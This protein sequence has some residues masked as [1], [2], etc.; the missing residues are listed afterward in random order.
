MSTRTYT[1]TYLARVTQTRTVSDVDLEDMDRQIL[2]A[3]EAGDDFNGGPVLTSDVDEILE[4][5]DADHED[6]VAIDDWQLTI[7]RT[8]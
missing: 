8:R 6:V 5:W 1:R 3:W 7:E 4:A 2:G